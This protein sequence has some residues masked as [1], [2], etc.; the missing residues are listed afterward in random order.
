METIKIKKALFMTRPLTI[1]LF[2]SIFLTL[3]ACIQADTVVKVKTDGSGVIEET[4][5]MKK[6][7]LQQLKTMMEEMAKSM[8]EMMTE[9]DNTS[10]PQQGSDAKSKVA[11]FDI[12]DEAKLKE[13]ANDMGEGVTYL[14][15][16]RKVTEDFEGYTVIYAFKEINKVKIN[17]NPGEKVP[18]DP[19]QKS[20]DTKRAKEYITFAFTKGKPA[21]LLIKSPKN[22]INKK[23]E[24]VSGDAKPPQNTDEVS[25][26][27]IAQMKEIFQGMKIALS[28]F[29]DGKILETNATHREGS[30]I[31]VLEL[32]FGKLLEIPE[33]FKK[34]NQ[35]QPKTV[36]EYKA[37]MQNLPGVKVDVNNEIRIRFDS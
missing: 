21:E 16:S 10:K 27:V 8:D 24:D 13:R 28:V 37:L 6:D 35:S 33:Q 23:S 26:E 36:E 29:V 32:D 19:Q 2:C 12:F 34:F 15:G 17:Q 9:G 18:S 7:L 1:F 22:T 20:T 3:T 31:T 11:T 14:K 5:L 30:K 4:F 25:E